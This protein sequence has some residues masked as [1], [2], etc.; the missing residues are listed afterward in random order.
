MLVPPAHIKLM[1]R[2]TTLTLTTQLVG[3]DNL[4]DEKSAHLGLH[5]WCRNAIKYTAPLR[6]RGCVH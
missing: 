2:D 5:I 1:C 3:P 6:I 4:R